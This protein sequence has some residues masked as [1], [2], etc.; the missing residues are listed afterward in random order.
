MIDS[1]CWI[2]LGE[3]LNELHSHLGGFSQTDVSSILSNLFS[4]DE[5]NDG[6][7]NTRKNSLHNVNQS[8]SIAT[9]TTNSILKKDHTGVQISLSVL[10]NNEVEILCY[11]TLVF[12]GFF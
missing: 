1:F 11:C 5:I 10:Y 9:T 2:C 6:Q 3:M 12:W 8:N 7:L 4:V